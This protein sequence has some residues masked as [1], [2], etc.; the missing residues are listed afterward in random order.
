MPT[1]IALTDCLGLINLMLT[2]DELGPSFTL[3]G[4][5]CA[6]ERVEG[7]VTFEA[8]SPDFGLSVIYP[9]WYAGEHG[10]PAH[11]TTVGDPIA[12]TRWLPFERTDKLALIA[13]LPLSAIDQTLCRVAA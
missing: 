9:G 4:V 5:Q 1:P 12:C 3:D 2:A 10:Q 11:I 7:H 13:G 8:V 6:V